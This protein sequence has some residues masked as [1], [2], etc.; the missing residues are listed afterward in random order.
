MSP[1]PSD[2]QQG[3]AILMAAVSMSL[4][5][6]CREKEV[7]QCLIEFEKK[8]TPN[9]IISKISEEQFY[10]LFPTREYSQNQFLH[11]KVEFY[12]PG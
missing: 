4:V 8:K 9:D 7:Y 3:V 10:I 5:A 2:R 11:Q 12:A 6:D 1:H